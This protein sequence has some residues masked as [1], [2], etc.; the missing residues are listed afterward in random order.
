MKQLYCIYDPEGKAR[1]ET[2]SNAHSGYAW[3]LY[4]IYLYGKNELKNTSFSQLESWKTEKQ[5]EG[6]T[7][8]PIQIANLE[9]EVVIPKAAWDGARFEIEN[10]KGRVEFLESMIDNGVGFEDLQ[11]Q[12]DI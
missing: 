3:E 10:L 5:K 1:L 8:K 6:Y 7:V 4:M 2:I 12:D 9:E 11:G